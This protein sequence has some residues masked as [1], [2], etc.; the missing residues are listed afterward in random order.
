[1]GRS[2]WYEKLFLGASL[3]GIHED[4]AGSI[5]DT[6]SADGGSAV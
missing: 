6:W 4:N 5:H 3:K 2:F 1:V